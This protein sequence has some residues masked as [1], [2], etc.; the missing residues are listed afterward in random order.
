MAQE[1]NFKSFKYSVFYMFLLT[2]TAKRTAA[3]IW[4]FLDFATEMEKHFRP[5]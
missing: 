2:S 5:N 1:N 3:K 4:E